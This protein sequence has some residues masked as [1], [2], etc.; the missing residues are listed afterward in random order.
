MK[1]EEIFKEYKK[2][3]E[4]LEVNKEGLLKSNQTIRF[5]TYPYIGSN[6]GRLT[7]ILFIGLDVGADEKRGIQTF[8]ERRNAI[9][10]KEIQLHN[11]HIAG[12]Y[13]CALFFLK[14]KLGLKTFWKQNKNKISSQH[15]LK[16]IVNFEENPLSYVSLT[17]Y[18]KFVTVGRKNRT[19]GLDRKFVHKDYEEKLLLKEIE[20]LEPKIIIFQSKQFLTKKFKR[21]IYKIKKLTDSKIYIGLHPSH[22]GNKS[23]EYL[24]DSLTLL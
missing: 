5:V 17:N 12:T 1:R 11:P 2:F 20:L 18:H 3:L 21:L 24:I 8:E 15:I 9:E 23:P 19:G 16:K 6:Y 22:R 7:R 4:V 13:I 10:E 14:E